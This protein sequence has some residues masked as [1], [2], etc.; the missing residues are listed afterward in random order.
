MSLAQVLTE[1]VPRRPFLNL[2]DTRDHGDTLRLRL[3]SENLCEASPR[4][5]R[6]SAPPDAGTRD[7]HYF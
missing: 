5:G 3:A 7:G 2:A 4:A 1:L 6:K